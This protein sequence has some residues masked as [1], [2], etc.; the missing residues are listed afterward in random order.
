LSEKYKIEADKILGEFSSVLSAIE[1]NGTYTPPVE[2]CALRNDS[3]PVKK[4]IYKDAIAQAPYKND[5]GLILVE[6]KKL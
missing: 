3:S 2:K 5:K 6:R 4:E 1:E